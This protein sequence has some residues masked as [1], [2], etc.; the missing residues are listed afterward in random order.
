MG[1][2][3]ELDRTLA[4]TLM[5]EFMRLQLI[6]GE[7]LTK[8]LLAFCTDL[9]TSCEVLTSDFARAMNLHPDDPMSRQ[10]KAIIQKFQQSTSMKMN[11]PLM[12]LEAAR[13]DM[14]GFLWSC[15]HEI[16]SQS[17]SRELIKELSQKL[18]AHTSRVQ[19]VVHAPK[20]DERAVFQQVMV[21]LAMD[22]PLEANFFQGILEG[23]AGRLSL[24]SP[25]VADPPT[26]AK[27]GMSQRWVATLREAVIRTEGRDIDL[28][29][30]THNVI[31]PGLHLDY[32]P[33]FLTRRVDDIA[34]TLTS[35][36][37]SGLT[38]NI[39]QLQRPGIPR[40]PPPFKADEVVWGHGRAPVK[41]GAP[42]PSHN[43]GMVSK[44]QAGEGEAPENRPHDHGESD[45]DQPLP[46]PDP[47]EV[48]GV[49]ISDDEDIDLTIDVPQAASTPISE[50]V[51]SQK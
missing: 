12:E 31:P 20:L 46:E 45:Q 28:E 11:L 25:G 9:E 39:C 10:V 26:S 14:E 35:P 33:D 13:E 42:D 43:G 4:R 6:I 19:E 37:L 30:V 23:L 7:D 50:P 1:S 44:M 3:R 36:L 29:Q 21:G 8:S 40:R 34:P 38:S 15:L 48:A 32:G 49:I 17:E 41:P 5:A 47:E 22:Q 16:S 2:V 18:S 27:A 24:M 51:L